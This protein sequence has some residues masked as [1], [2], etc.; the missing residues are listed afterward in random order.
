MQE[1]FGTE[2]PADPVVR[3][4]VVAS[5]E[6]LTRGGVTAAVRDLVR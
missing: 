1:V 4:L 5:L 3:E 2:L 6:A